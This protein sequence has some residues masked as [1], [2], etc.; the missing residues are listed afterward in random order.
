[1]ERAHRRFA[2]TDDA[3]GLPHLSSHI[4]ELALPNNMDA[5]L[6]HVIVTTEDEF[7]QRQRG[8]FTFEIVDN[9]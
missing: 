8:I 4:W 1:V 5:G 3:Y 6:H 2:D 9:Q 7:G